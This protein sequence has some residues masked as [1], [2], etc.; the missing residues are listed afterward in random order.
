MGR[1][2]Q[3]MEDNKIVELYTMRSEVAIA[4]TA[5]KYGT[6]AGRIAFNILKNKEDSE[7]CVSDAYLKLWNNIPP[8]KPSNLKAFLGKVVRNLALDK[9]EKDNAQKRGGG[10]V[11]LCLEELS[12][13][14]PQK[15][16]S[17]ENVTNIINEYLKTQ[18]PKKVKMFV[19]RYWYLDSIRD[20]SNI[21]ICTESNVKTTLFR[22]REELREKLNQEGINI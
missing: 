19:R 4:H 13:C 11:E 6:Y 21:C 12:D 22:M 3:I 9:Y 15:E 17:D 16:V 8:Q 18:D 2:P 7:E 10:Q 20:I 5:Q 14:I 1:G